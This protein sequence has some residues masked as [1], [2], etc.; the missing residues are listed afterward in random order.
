MDFNEIK[1]IAFH[2]AKT[3]YDYCKRK[4]IANAIIPVKIIENKNTFYIFVLSKAMIY[5]KEKYDIRINSKLLNKQDYNFLKYDDDNRQLFISFNIQFNFPI[6]PENVQIESNLLFLIEN[7]K[8]WYNNPIHSLS[9]PKIK[10]NINSYPTS[11]KYKPSFEQSEAVNNMKSKSL[12]YVWGAPGTG[13]TQ[14]VL[15]RCIVDY[16]K[17]FLKENSKHKIIVCA[18]T[19][20]SLEQILFGVFKVLE[21]ENIP[22]NLVIRLGMPS[23]EFANKYND[24]CEHLP[25]QNKIDNLSQKINE[26]NT[27]L[28]KQNEILEIKNVISYFEEFAFKFSETTQQINQLNKKKSNVENN[29]KNIEY[30]L[31]KIRIK[32]QDGKNSLFQNNKEKRKLL[33][34]IIKRNREKIQYQEDILKVKIYDLTEELTKNNNKKNDYDAELKNIQEQLSTIKKLETL[35]SDLFLWL[36][37]HKNSNSIAIQSLLNYLRDHITTSLNEFLDL[38]IKKCYQIVEE[39]TKIIAISNYSEM[40]DTEIHIEI[41][42]LNKKYNELVDQGTKAQIEKSNVI[43]LTADRFILEYELL[44]DIKDDDS[45]KIEHIFVDEAA[46]LCMIKGLV[47]F[48]FNKPITLLGDH[49]QLPP[50]FDCEDNFIKE[51]PDLFLWEIPIIYC[52]ELF[53]NDFQIFLNNYNANISPVFNYLSKIDLNATYRFGD[54]LAEI[55]K[56]TVYS[57]KFHSKNNKT[58]TQITIIN[59]VKVPTNKPRVSPLEI[60]AIKDFLT[61]YSKDLNSFTILTPYKN[62]LFELQKGLPSDFNCMTIHASQGQEWDTVIISAVDTFFASRTKIIN[63]AV[64]RAKKH[65]VIVCNKSDWELR[66]KYLISK[67]I[68]HSNA[69]VDYKDINSYMI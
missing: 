61:V 45:Y 9:L 23:K 57:D 55:L 54:N 15:A 47:L 51:N 6:T 37:K 32:I 25:I 20:N 31:S 3:Y 11:E 28:I 29:I 22:T 66:P 41:E 4:N 39:N 16:L 58:P 59:A 24:S 30:E 2:S 52:E 40:D 62:Q 10:P 17:N 8:K 38:A 44:N 35:K 63:T 12:S 42:N 68:S 49:M 48:S 33:N 43:A 67:I 36:K 34:R 64:S 69:I 13:K 27:I 56:N 18:P 7:V 14:F 50:V 1:N 26:L 60:S 5:E 19:N 65:L 46:Y 21:A 53:Q